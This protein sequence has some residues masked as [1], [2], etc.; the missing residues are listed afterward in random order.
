MEYLTKILS[1]IFQVHNNI[2]ILYISLYPDKVKFIGVPTFAQIEFTIQVRLNFFDL[3]S[4]IMRRSIMDQ[5]F[6]IMIK[7]FPS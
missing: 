1:F 7:T 5:Y 2:I 4:E 6:S 3:T